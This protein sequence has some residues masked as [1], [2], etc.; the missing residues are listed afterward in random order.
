MKFPEFAAGKPAEGVKCF[1]KTHNFFKC[2]IRLSI[3]FEYI[4][5]Q[6]FYKTEM[7]IY[8]VNFFHFLYNC[9]AKRREEIQAHHS[10]PLESCH[11]MHSLW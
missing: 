4:F 1:D 5:T 10:I 2:K 8:C 3:E 7:F 9:Q 6:I 11:I